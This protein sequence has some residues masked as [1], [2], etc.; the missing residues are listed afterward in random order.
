MRDYDNRGY[1]VFRAP[2]PGCHQRGE[3]LHYVY[4]CNEV[5]SDIMWA[6]NLKEAKRH[7]KDLKKLRP[8]TEIYELPAGIN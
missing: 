8:A 2:C 1:F 7:L 3:E 6:D 5:T 4:L